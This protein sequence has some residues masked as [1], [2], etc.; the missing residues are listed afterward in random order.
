MVFDDGSRKIMN[1]VCFKFC[2]QKCF[3]P[4]FVDDIEF[5]YGNAIPLW[6]FGFLY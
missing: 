5:G 1:K 3:D 2:L 6:L 4:V